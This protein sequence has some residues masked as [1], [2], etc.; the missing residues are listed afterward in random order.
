M[1]FIT[2]ENN[3]FSKRNTTSIVEYKE[4]LE[5]F[6]KHFEDEITLKIKTPIFLGRLH[7]HYIQ[8]MYV[9]TGQILYIVDAERTLGDLLN[10]NIDSL[11]SND[12]DNSYTLFTLES[13]QKL[14]ENNRIFEDVVPGVFGPHILQELNLNGYK[15]IIDVE[16]DIIKSEPAMGEYRKKHPHLNTIGI[17]RACLRIANPLFTTTVNRDSSVSSLSLDNTKKYE[18]FRQLLEN[19]N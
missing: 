17:L 5:R 2:K 3:F 19:K 4:C 10:V 16:N 12:I 11:V 14:I 15:T 1:K 9:N 13:L 6:S 7:L 8:N 18:K